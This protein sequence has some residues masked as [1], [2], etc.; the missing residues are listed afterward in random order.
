[1]GYALRSVM[2]QEDTTT[3]HSERFK[4]FREV[5]ETRKFRVVLCA[6]AFAV[7]RS[8]QVLKQILAAER[9][10]GGL[11]YLQCEPS[12]ISE[13][14]APHSRRYDLPTGDSSSAKYIDASAL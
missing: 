6:E 10:R 13:V 11:D 9:E 7:M 8:V 12:I 5:Y 2:W 3:R 14:R 1:M 4:V